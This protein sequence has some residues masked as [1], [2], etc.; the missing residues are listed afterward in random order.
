MNTQ[1]YW[2]VVF[3]ADSWQELLDSKANVSGFPRLD[4]NVKMIMP[5]DYL[6]CYQRL[7]HGIGSCWIGALKVISG[8]IEDYTP[9]WI[10]GPYSWRV[11]VE[12]VVALT[13]KTGV[14]IHQ[15][16]DRLLIYKKWPAFF[17][18]YPRN[19]PDSD[20]KLILQVLQEA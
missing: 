11:G 7:E 18:D 17:R 19:I 6:L 2:S 14:S 4:R 12:I 3:G 5:G 1:N 13:P 10:D 9:I 16:G 8:V 15:L 20:G